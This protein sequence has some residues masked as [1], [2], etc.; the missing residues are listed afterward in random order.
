MDG[1]RIEKVEIANFR[2][3]SDIELRLSHPESGTGQDNRTTVIVGANN[4]GKT[5][6]AEIFRRFAKKL[7][8]RLEDF[9]NASYGLFCDAFMLYMERKSDAEVRALIP[10]IELRITLSYDNAL[11]EYG[12]L[13]PFVVDLDDATTTAVVVARF[14]LDEG[15]IERLFEGFT[16]DGEL[17]ELEKGRLLRL[18]S[19]R[20]PRFFKHTLLAEDPTDGSNVRRFKEWAPF[21]ELFSIR[22]IN[23]QRGLDDITT[24]DSDVLAKILERLFLAAD[25][26]DAESASN[27][28]AE[29][30][31]AAVADVQRSLNDRFNEQ[32]HD[33]MPTFGKFG[34]PGLGGPGIEVETTLEASRLLGATKV[35]YKGYQGVPLP[36]SYNGLGTRNLIFVLI[37]LLEFYRE[38][39]V[40]GE[41][42]GVQLVFIEEPEAHLHPQVQEVFIRHLNKLGALFVQL[43][44][45]GPRWPVQFVVSTHS[46]HIANEASFRAIR[47]FHASSVKERPA[48][49]C[50]TVKD[51]SEG[52]GGVSEEDE[53]FLHQ[54]L[55]LTRADLFFA[56]KAI[57]IEG[58][59]ERLLM[60]KMIEKFDA[61]SSSGGLTSQYLTFLEVGGAFAHKFFPLLDFLGLPSLVVTDI[62]AVRPNDKGRKESCAVH[63][64]TATSNSTIKQWF[65]DRDVT[66]ISLIGINTSDPCLVAESGRRR[67]AYQV[68]DREDLACG[69]T[70]EDA[71]V[72][73]NPER[74]MI[75]SQAVEAV[76][77]EAARLAG[78]QKKAEFA[79]R[80]ATDEESWKT[81]RYILEGL[82]WLSKFNAPETAAGVAAA[83]INSPDSSI[84]EMAAAE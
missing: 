62:D 71:F 66:P 64:S 9:S 53:K 65:G 6:L 77:E 39:I 59:A 61:D 49:R 54:Y 60:P 69:R 40:R 27:K 70:F 41:Q 45:G 17:D 29:E 38:F 81:P 67:L 35:R 44:K 10:S 15:N 23:A 25:R 19:D 51:L 18:L 31:K 20:I 32:V 72:L 48:V 26:S 75:D 63:K 79:L 37:Q 84:R 3:L 4:T 14:E 28:A 24:R 22:F 47:Y 21:D 74:F 50:T 8:F 80:F 68:S 56:D 83:V 2:L 82:R 78:E 30:L 57:L 13:A 5:S 11:Q 58:T 36:E 52:L 76:E 1:L 73:A 16:P 55:T 7:T 12:P 33:L 42:P 46:S 34:Y 43:D